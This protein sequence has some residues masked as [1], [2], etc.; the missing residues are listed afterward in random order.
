LQLLLPA[1]ALPAANLL[2]NS[3]LDLR[4]SVFLSLPPPG[5]GL[6]CC[7]PHPEASPGKGRWHTV[8]ERFLNRGYAAPPPVERF[9]SRSCAY[10]YFSAHFFVNFSP[11]LFFPRR[12]NRYFFKILHSIIYFQFCK[13]YRIFA[14]QIFL[15]FGLKCAF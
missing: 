2:T 8:P 4:I 1:P 13:N 6:F 9:F 14:V 12:S 7:R 10:F 5:G 11:I 15:K 3:P